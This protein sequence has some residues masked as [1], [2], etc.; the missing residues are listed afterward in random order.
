MGCRHPH[1]SSGSSLP[2]STTGASPA[3]S[4]PVY[5]DS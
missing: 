4:S 3:R 1:P 2:A 5:M